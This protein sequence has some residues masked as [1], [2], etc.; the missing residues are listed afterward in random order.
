MEKII[1]EL[2]TAGF[3][4]KVWEKGEKC[5]LYIYYNGKDMGYLSV[6]SEGIKIE[7]KGKY[8]SISDSLRRA[9]FKPDQFGVWNLT[10]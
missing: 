2:K 1:A 5:R 4:A 6:E 8:V 7:H 3:S 10:A 9:G